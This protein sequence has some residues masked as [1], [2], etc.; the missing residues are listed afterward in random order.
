MLLKRSN[1]NVNDTPNLS[2]YL[3]AIEDRPAYKRTLE[4]VGKNKNL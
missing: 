1:V 4:K 2:R 3:K